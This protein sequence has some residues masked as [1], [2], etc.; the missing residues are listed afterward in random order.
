MKT[1]T[2]LTLLLFPIMMWGQINDK[3]YSITVIRG[4]STGALQLFDGNTQ[5]GWFPGWN[6]G[7][8][9]VLAKIKF[10][11]KV[12][13]NKLKLFDWVGQPNFTLINQTDTI[14][15]K[16]NQ[17]NKWQTKTFKT[18][19]VDEI[20]IS[21]SD[22]QGDIPITELEFYY[23]STVTPPNTKKLTG[24]ALSIGTNGFH[25]IP[26]DLIPCQNIRIYQMVQWSWTPKGLAVNPTV[27]ADGM[28]DEYYQELKNKNITAI[29]CINKVP[30]WSHESPN[31]PEWADLKMNDIGTN[32]NDPLSYR[33]ISQYGFQLAARYGRVKYPS[34]DLKVNQEPRWNGDIVNLLQSGL[35]LLSYI[36]LENEPDRPWKNPT[37]KYTAEQFAAFM[38]AVYDGHEGR[39]G[40]GYGIKTADPSMKV[41]MAGISAINT[42]Y[43]E[44]MNQ[45]FKQNRTDQIFAA[46]VINVHH[47]CNSANPPFPAQT[48][49]LYLG[50]GIDPITDKLY[51]RL[52]V[53]K[54]KVGRDYLS[55]NNNTN[56]DISNIDP[57]GRKNVKFW[58]TEFG[59]DTNPCSTPLCQAVENDSIQAEWILQSFLIA[60]KAGYEKSFVYNLSDE[61]SADK[62]YVFGSSGLLNNNLEVKRS[63]K[64]VVW[65][66]EILNNKQYLGETK[67]GWMVFTGGLVIK[68]S[69]KVE[70]MKIKKGK[71]YLI[72]RKMAKK[73]PK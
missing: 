39:M 51:Q 37:H 59:Y 10:T 34:Q 29:P 64:R 68:I 58:L 16:L 27:Q 65:L 4:Q 57:L 52:N 36:E 3:L 32:P 9:P 67:E 43:I 60:I 31:D 66:T 8:Y 63:H 42:K 1:Q 35:D 30:N 19:E 38:S 14:N 71:Y 47:Y 72:S 2:L 56:N 20:L 12:K 73:L 13:F 18:M 53:L 26:T 41:V 21:I 28:Y 44:D 24:D 46:D 22:I 15:V 6:A 54:N 55:T 70:I 62:G 61:M 5:S 45:W 69:P 17:F 33:S 49:N 11:E 40:K 25:W 50:D 48:V 23:D 7:D